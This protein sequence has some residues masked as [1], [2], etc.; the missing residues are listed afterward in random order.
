M[1]LQVGKPSDIEKS[2]ESKSLNSK[3][4][5]KN[6]DTLCKKMIWKS[7]Q[8]FY[9]FEAKCSMTWLK[10]NKILASGMIRI[11]RRRIPRQICPFEIIENFL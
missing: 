3:S 9:D 5:F 11:A 6:E 4:T 2:T 10:P 8:I 1:K 7:W